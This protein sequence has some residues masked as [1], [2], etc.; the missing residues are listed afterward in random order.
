MN[1]IKVRAAGQ[2]F[3]FS[4]ET[5]FDNDGSNQPVTVTFS[6]SVTNTYITMPEKN[7]M[8]WAKANWLIL[9]LIFLVLVLII[10]FIFKNAKYAKLKQAELERKRK[11]I[12]NG[13]N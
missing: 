3:D 5:D 6:G 2:I 8:Q 4:Y 13:S 10:F 7:A 12:I 11:R 9:V 1:N